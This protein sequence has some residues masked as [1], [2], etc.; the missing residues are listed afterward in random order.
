M[1]NELRKK[2]KMDLF[3]KLGA[4]ARSN[5]IITMQVMSGQL[6]FQEVTVKNPYDSAHT[7]DIKITDADFN[8]GKI[9]SPE[10][11]LVDGEEWK[12]WYEQGKCEQQ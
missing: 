3:Q 6:G 1:V 9:Q 12:F 7:F 8:D 11:Q 10:F 5:D 4:T 2:T